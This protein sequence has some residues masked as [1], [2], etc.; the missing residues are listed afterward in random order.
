MRPIVQEIFLVLLCLPN[1]LA[2]GTDVTEYLGEMNNGRGFIVHINC[3]AGDLTAK[4]G[5][6]NDNIVQGLDRDIEDVERARANIRS[7][8]DY[9]RISAR[10]FNGRDLPYIDNTANLVIAESSAGVAQEEVMRVLQ[11]LGV[12]FIGGEKIVKPWPDNID[13]WTHYLHDPGNNAVADDDLVAPPKG[14][15][16]VAGPLWSRRHN[17]LDV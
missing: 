15:Q 5:A 8:G 1:S 11:P 4:L 2:W 6:N 16:W 12:A 7:L 14:L 10:H 13:E 17:T 9:G 3:D